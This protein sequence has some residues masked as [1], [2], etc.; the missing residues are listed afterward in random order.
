MRTL[1]VVDDEML[2]ADGLHDI[3][4][5]A[6]EGRMN[7]ICRYSAKAALEAAAEQPVDLL[8]T[9][10]NMPNM[11]GLELH[12][13]IQER[14][15]ECQVIYLT[16]YSDFGYARTALDQ[17]AFAY[18]LKGEGDDV[19]ISTVE[20]ALETIKERETAEQAPEAGEGQDWMRGL[21][22][23]IRDHLN[24]DLSLN[25]LAE[26]CHFHPAY[27]SRV[28]KELTGT[29]VGD[30]INKA[31]EEKAGE[32]LRK[33]RM[34]VL[35]IS[36]EMGFATDNYFCRWFRKRTGMSPQHYREGKTN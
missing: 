13:A 6:L 19:V 25:R 31:R 16:G 18:L 22:E 10:I 11:T 26:V 20:R 36:R 15:P 9:D 23:Y 28:Y 4:Q 34:T 14:Y 32:L 35:E 21:Q 17:R 33:T 7:V 1:L 29:T 27:L 24:E 3:L 8:L 5:R 12:R 30:Y 2:I